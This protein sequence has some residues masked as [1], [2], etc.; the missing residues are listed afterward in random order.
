MLREKS[1]ERERSANRDKSANR[2][3][4]ANR[5]KSAYSEED[6]DHLTL[7]SLQDEDDEWVPDDDCGIEW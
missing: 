1:D 2:V 7:Q 3:M 6:K 5:E 4:S